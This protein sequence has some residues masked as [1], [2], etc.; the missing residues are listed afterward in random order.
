M[1]SLVHHISLLSMKSKTL[2]SLLI[3][4]G[5]TACGTVNVAYDSTI[6]APDDFSISLELKATDMFAQMIRD[7]PSMLDL[8]SEDF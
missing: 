1:K 7:D 5:L 6:R 8:Q 3:I 4:F 2:L